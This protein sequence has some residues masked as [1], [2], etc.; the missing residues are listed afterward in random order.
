MFIIAS[1]LFLFDK[2]L[3]NIFYKCKLIKYVYNPDN[4]GYYL[5]NISIVYTFGLDIQNFIFHRLD[6]K[7]N[8]INKWLAK[9]QDIV[10]IFF[11]LF[12]FIILFLSYI[13]DNIKLANLIS[14]STLLIYTIY[15]TYKQM[16]KLN[17]EIKN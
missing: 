6:K 13:F 5:A 9:F 2:D 3:K 12:I 7:N 14:S 1:L 8:F 17:S 16:H 10:L 11:P 15:L 4:I